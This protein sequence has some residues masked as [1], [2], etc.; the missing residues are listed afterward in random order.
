M[1]YEQTIILTRYETLTT[2]KSLSQDL[3]EILS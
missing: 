3:F 2:A 1:N